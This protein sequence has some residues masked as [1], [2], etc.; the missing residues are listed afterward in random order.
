MTERKHDIRRFCVVAA[1]LLLTLVAIDVSFGKLA[2]RLFRSLPLRDK[3]PSTIAHRHSDNPDVYLVGSSRCHH[4]YVAT[5]LSD[6]L[7]AWCGGSLSL[8]NYGLDA[9]YV[10]SSL[11]AIESLVHRCTPKLIILD[12]NSHEFDRVYTHVVDVASPLYWSDSVVRRYINQS[13]CRNRVLML[14]SLYRY[15]NAMPLRVAELLRMPADTL[16]GFLPL[17]RTMDTSAV[18]PPGPSLSDFHPDSLVACSF[19]RVAALCHQKGI[20]FVVADSPRYRPDDNSEYVKRL[21]E[22]CEVPFIDFYS[23]G[24]FNSHPELFYEPAHLNA[25]GA[26]V[27]TSL[28]AEKLKEIID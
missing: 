25:E 16:M 21:C 15:R 7:N 12:A 3:I 4:H 13:D 10:N 14:S 2:D 26:Q 8:Y 23:T 20:R 6:S 27:F 28:F 19:R 1:L 5:Q 9:V 17:N 18:Y 22:E 11:C 24:Y